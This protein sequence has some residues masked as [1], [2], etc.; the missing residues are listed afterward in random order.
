MKLVKVILGSVF[1]SLLISVV[2]SGINYTPMSERRSDTYYFS[3][4]E[5][6]LFS[7]IYLTPVIVIAGLIAFL[8]YILF[9]KRTSL[10]KRSNILTASALSISLVVSAISLSIFIERKYNVTNDIY[11]VPEGYEG[12][13]FVFYNVKGAPPVE[14][15]DGFEVHTINDE[16]YFVTSTPDLDYGTI[17][18]QYFYVSED[19]KRTPIDRLCVSGFGMGGTESEGYNLIYTG[20]KLT[21]TQCSEDFM[22]KGFTQDYDESSKAMIHKVLKQY[23][24][25]EVE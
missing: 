10:S 9:K 22:V 19:G 7:A 14:I 11:L 3:F 4:F 8:V 12:D 16:G 1:I 5:H 2:L 6:F 15:E 18:D 13:V 25:M 23:Y 21:K 24:Q 20:F 17:T